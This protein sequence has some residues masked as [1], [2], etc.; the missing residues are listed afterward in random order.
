MLAAQETDHLHHQRQQCDL[1]EQEVHHL[2]LPPD[3]VCELDLL[4]FAPTEQKLHV[5]PWVSRSLTRLGYWL[6]L[7]TRQVQHH[8]S[9]C[10]VL[11]WGRVQAK[12]WTR[13]FVSIWVKLHG[14]TQFFI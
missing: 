5:S 1:D 10:G 2:R 11:S 9:H 7:K 12:S 3:L 13:N 14:H 4:I 8:M 6:V